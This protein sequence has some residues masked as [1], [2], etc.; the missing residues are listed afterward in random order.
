MIAVDLK[1]FVSI[2]CGLH[3]YVAILTETHKVTYR[4]KYQEIPIVVKA[5]ESL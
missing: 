4:E 5:R 1:G 3:K 2:G